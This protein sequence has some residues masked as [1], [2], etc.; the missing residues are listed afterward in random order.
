MNR[1][2]PGACKKLHALTMTGM[3]TAPRCSAAARSGGS[4]S[5][6]MKS[7]AKKSALTRSIATWDAAI[8]CRISA[9]P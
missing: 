3:M 7:E 1:D 4:R 2:R 5:L 9:R 6:A 8:A